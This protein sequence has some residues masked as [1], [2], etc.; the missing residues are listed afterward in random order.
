MN[1]LMM[2]LEMGQIHNP[3][4]FSSLSD[5]GW[6]TF[7]A[8]AEVKLRQSF[9]IRCTYDAMRLGQQ[10]AVSW[11]GLA[12]PPPITNIEVIGGNSG[13]PGYRV[14]M[15]QAWIDQCRRS[16]VAKI[17]LP[18]PMQGT[19][20]NMVLKTLV[21]GSGANVPINPFFYKVSGNKRC[22]PRVGVKAIWPHIPLESWVVVRRWYERMG[23]KIDWARHPYGRDLERGRLI[24][25]TIMHI[26]VQR[27]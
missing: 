16:R 10:M 7:G 25:S 9:Y 23:G 18:L 14:T 5:L 24:P 1:I 27:P 6:N 2:L 8:Q 11:P 12:L 17:K 19:P 20:Q 3:T 4:E 15:S 13:Q 26:Q 22:A 21:E